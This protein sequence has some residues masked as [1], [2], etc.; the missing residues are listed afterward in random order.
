MAANWPAVPLGDLTKG[1]LRHGIYKPPQSFGSG[2]RVLKMGT[3]L[4]ENRLGAQEMPRA[5]LTSEEIARYG[6]LVGD[7]LFARTSTMPN[8]LGKCAI[9]VTHKEP[10]VFDGN[11]LCATLDTDRADPRFVYYFFTSE[12]GQQS[13]Q[14]ITGGT[15]SRSV[16]A[17]TFS[18]VE[19]PCPPL[20]VQNAIARVLGSFDDKIE[21]NRRMNQTLEEICRAL[22]KFWFVD[23]GPVRA[24]MEGRW[25]KGESLPGMPADMWD[26]WPSEFEESE[27]GEI[28]KGW[29]VRPLAEVA[30]FTRGVSYRG[31]DLAD[32]ETAL[33]SLKCA[34]R[35]GVYREDG[36][37]PYRGK[38]KESQIV[39]SGDVVVSHTDVTQRAEVIG[40]AY[41]VRT[42][43]RFSRL[44]A[45]LD[46]AI[47][48]PNGVGLSREYL[49]FSLSEERFRDHAY[50]YTNGTTVLH[51]SSQALPD[52]PLLIPP[53]D[54][55]RDFSRTV[56]LQNGLLD[57]HGIES[58]LLGHLRDTLLPKLLSGEIRVKVDS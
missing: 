3:F 16:P 34:G 33:V 50:G 32:S 49:A 42:S 17:T 48:R 4:R 30:T 21:L 5:R 41:R 12:A 39:E 35:G 29:T 9:V 19:V 47:V 26:L 22:F 1:G 10:F 2:T 58:E 45:S 36:L 24:K 55:V 6:V 40:R 8:G 52:Y 53:S 43:L 14:E 28:P 7:L 31:E 27:I 20:A 38:Y 37:K 46:M 13:I 57:E 56:S 23:F 18:K 11:I 15:Q 51:L 54:V 44:V 25:K